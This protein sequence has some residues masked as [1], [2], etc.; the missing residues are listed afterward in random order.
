MRAGDQYFEAYGFA[1][2]EKKAAYLGEKT[3][4]FY[5]KSLANNPNLLA[6]KANMAM[7][8]VSTQTPM[9]GI[10]LLREVP[11]AGSNQ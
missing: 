8:Y 4:E 5:Q 3:R 2:D 10:M 11:S 7:T 1:V 9:Q 6:A